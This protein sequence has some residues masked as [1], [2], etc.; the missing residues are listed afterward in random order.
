MKTQRE[1]VEGLVA[2]REDAPV[3]SASSSQTTRTPCS[4]CESVS[5][6]VEFLWVRSRETR[7]SE[8]TDRTARTERSNLTQVLSEF[9]A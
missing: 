6:A 9:S 5:L 3:A 7:S 2:L 1:S 4:A 8:R